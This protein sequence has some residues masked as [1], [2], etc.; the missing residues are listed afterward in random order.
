[1]SSLLKQRILSKKKVYLFHGKTI[2]TH[3]KY[4]SSST[5]LPTDYA[6]F[7]KKKKVALGLAM[8]ILFS[9]LVV[10]HSVTLTLT[11]QT[12]GSK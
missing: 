5:C 10:C 11:V 4:V 9:H 12:L 2:S 7:V 8:K 3:E 6:C 1:M